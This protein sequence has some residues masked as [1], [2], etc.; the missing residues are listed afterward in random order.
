ML[1]RAGIV[2][3]HKKLR[4]LY[5]EEGLSVRRRRGRKRTTGTREPMPVPAGP[6]ERWSLDFLADV[7]GPGG[8]SAS[9]R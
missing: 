5:R 1:E 6:G 8:A 2:T 7:F 4:R 3:N 9:G